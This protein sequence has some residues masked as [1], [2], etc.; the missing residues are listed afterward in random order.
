MYLGRICVMLN[1]K[2]DHISLAF[3]LDPCSLRSIFD[4][5][6]TYDLK[7]I[8]SDFDAISHSDVTY[9]VQ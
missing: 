9:M 2:S 5:K 7:T 4:E 8:G 3:D 1:H 6:T